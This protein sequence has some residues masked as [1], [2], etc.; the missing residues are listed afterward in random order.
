M[1][2]EGARKGMEEGV[3][4]AHVLD[5]IWFGRSP[6]VR[7]LRLLLLRW[8]G[9]A[10]GVVAAYIKT[11]RIPDTRAGS[12]MMSVLSDLIATMLG[13]VDAKMH[14]QENRV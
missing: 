13:V 4:H 3:D 9:H 1:C 11:M 6:P 14:R 8:C 7:D 2:A 10:L 12:S 5:G